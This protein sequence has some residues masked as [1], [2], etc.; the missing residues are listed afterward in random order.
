MNQ[1]NATTEVNSSHKDQS[2]EGKTNYTMNFNF[3]F[4]YDIILC[5]QHHPLMGS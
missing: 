5:L 4:F 1:A 2:S 3:I